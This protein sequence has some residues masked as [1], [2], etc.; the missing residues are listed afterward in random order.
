[1]TEG[2][3][4]HVRLDMQTSYV[5]PIRRYSSG[6]KTA[7]DTTGSE[8]AGWQA[9]GAFAS[10]DGIGVKKKCLLMPPVSGSRI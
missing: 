8:L 3:H 1:M 5:L 6:H 9:K 2:R 7:D 10:G 4:G